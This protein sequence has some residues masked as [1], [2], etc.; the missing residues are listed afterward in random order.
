MNTSWVSQ[1]LAEL[2]AEEMRVAAAGETAVERDPSGRPMVGV[3][4]V[5]VLE[6]DRGG[7]AA[8][9]GLGAD[10]ADPA[11]DR[12]AD[13]ARVLQLAVVRREHPGAREPH[14]VGGGLRLFPARGRELRAARRRI[15]R[16]AVPVGQDQQVDLPS[17]RG[18]LRQRA[19][20]ADLRVVRV[21][22]HGKRRAGPRRGLGVLLHGPY[23][24]RATA[25]SWRNRTSVRTGIP[26]PPAGP[27]SLPCSENAGP[28]MSRWTHGVSP[29]NSARNHDAV[30]APP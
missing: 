12:L 15:G 10:L 28:A 17:S 16:A 29:T 6:E 27:R 21:G 4:V 1:A 5:A 3:V 24:F 8:H 26:V 9:H 18:P 25:R 2:L 11:G 22:E 14:H 20:R 30:I 13:D 7:I 23:R 19:A